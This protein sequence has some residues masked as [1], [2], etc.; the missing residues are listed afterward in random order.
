MRSASFYFSKEN[1]VIL[2]LGMLSAAII[3]FQLVLMQVISIMQW[4]HFA[5]M[6]ISIA[7][8][9][10]G[11]A[12]TAL[13]LMREKLLSAASWLA[14]VL[15]CL[16]GIFMIFSVWLARLQVFQFDVYVLF[17]ERSQFGILAANYLI[18]FLPFFFG[19]LAI[20]ILLTK[21]AGNIG[22]FYFANLIGSGIGGVLL[23]FLLSVMFAIEALPVAAMLAVLASIMGFDLQRHKG[24][25]A[26][27]IMLG[28]AVLVFAFWLPGEV[29][30][31]QYKGMSRSLL[32][33]DARVV[34]SKPD[35]HGRVDVVA[36]NAMRYAPA[37]SF[38]YTGRVPV[39]K[40]VYTNGEFYGVIPQ[41]DTTVTNIHDFT[42][43]ALPYIMGARET[44]LLL[45][46]STGTALAHALQRGAAKVQAITAVHA[47]KALMENEFAQESSFLF[48]DKRAEVLYQDS[49]QFLFSAKDNSY[50][51]IILPRMEA[52]GGS[53]G[54]NALVEDYTL[55]I[56]AFSQMWD[57]LSEDGVIAVTSWMDYPPRTT[58]KI[59]A[60]LVQ[61]LG[62]QGV[63]DPRDHMV[64]VRSWGTITFVVQKSP[65]DQAVA[66]KI[67]S[68][69]REMLFDPVILPGFDPQ[70]ETLYN[71]LED[72]SFFSYLDKII[73]REDP[74]FFENYSFYVAPATDDKPYFGR[75][76]KT[77]EIQQQLKEYD[78]LPFLE[79]G[80]LI[81][82]I[83]LAQGAFLAIVLIIIPLFRLR[84]KSKS[85]TA[86]IFYFGALGLGYM[87][88]EIIF[89]QR[90]ILYF[91][92]PMYA[93]A[94]VISTMMIASGIGSYF[95]GRF[96][97]AHKVSAVS[98]LVVSL[99]ILLYAVSL[100]PLLMHTINLSLA[101]K[102]FI[103]FVLLSVPAFFMGMPFPS[104]IRV[105][106]ANRQDQI[107]WA[108]GINGSLSVIAT[109]L[110]TLIAVE[111]GFRVVM[112]FAMMLYL[113]A[114]AV[115][116]INFA[117]EKPS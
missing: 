36:S 115:A 18:F 42:T 97:L 57:K 51:A 52:F 71:Q 28:M 41:F 12:G 66:G 92:H 116:L 15:M 55:T 99:L 113:V 101:V 102:V 20:G 60:T 77:S 117:R 59:A 70:N 30:L 109:A 103:A 68:F 5:Y 108:W 78:D 64:A 1:R 74:D 86:T 3:A 53:A 81:V 46:A 11:A 38:T 84:S 26:G 83:T 6:I 31:S 8:L 111:M 21:N 10:F 114:F 61:A 90:F 93:I 37:L 19:A 4:Y 54:L 56:E 50:D 7:M 110:A 94:A 95:S 79:L 47:V 72:D 85:K 67:R 58:L 62:N 87:F 23:V 9:G 13:A 24:L 49:R 105:L 39:K 45:N 25:Q 40:N 17:V 35:I 44:V 32:L 69:C 107:P 65:L 33:P 22:K 73:S 16:S 100:T 91:G 48:H 112:F 43:E 80:Y 89:I 27:V 29:P 75:F 76:L 82:W 34:H 104:A 96:K 98:T 63:T 2:S 14:P 88:V 106:D